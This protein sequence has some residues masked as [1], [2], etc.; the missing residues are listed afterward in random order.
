MLVDDSRKW[1]QVVPEEVY[2]RRK[3]ELFLSESGKVLK[4]PA[5]GGGGVSVPGSV[6]EA[7]G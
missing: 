6:Q 3:E 2:V 1:P 7:S 4:R 5:Q